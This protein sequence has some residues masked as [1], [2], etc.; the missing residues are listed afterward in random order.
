MKMIISSILLITILA[1]CNPT[2]KLMKENDTSFLEKLMKTKPKQFSYYLANKDSLRLQIIY[3]KI[4]HTKNGQSSFHEYRFNVNDSMYFYPASTV[5]MPVA[6]LVLE[7]LNELNHPLINKNT[8]IKTRT[9]TTSS[10]TDTTPST[11]ENYIKQIF[12]VSDNDAFNHLYE[13]LGQGYIQQKLKEK[14]YT[15]AEIRHRL[16]IFLTPEQNKK[17]DTVSFYDSLGNLIRQQL[18]QYNNNNFPER[19][20][21]VGKGYYKDDQLVHQPFDF[22]LKNRIYLEDLHHILQSVLF[23]ETVPPQQRFNLTDEDYQFLYKWMSSYPRESKKPKYDSVKYWDAYAKFLLY[24]EEKK[25]VIKNIRIFN[26]VGDAYGF[27]TDVAYVVD[28][29]KNVEFMLS[30]TL[31][32]NEKGIFNNDDYQY[33]TVGLPFMKNLGR[34]IYDYE[35]KNNRSKN[36][37]IPERFLID[38]G[39]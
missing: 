15:G 3:T 7:K 2:K 13:F 25:P 21:L 23:P 9:Y 26:K 12:L 33:T 34:L 39:E 24:G 37:V 32:C 11:I 22:S 5:K 10:T 27:L 29:K 8:T 35:I 28:R 19:K 4:I 30:A 20:S 38:Y 6:F 36:R 16:Q 1:S 17:T 31:L 18:P 14:G